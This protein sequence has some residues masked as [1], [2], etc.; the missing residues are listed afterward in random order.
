MPG[1]PN[2]QILRE[3]ADEAAVNER[4]WE[5][6]ETRWRRTSGWDVPTGELGLLAS[7]NDGSH[8]VR[9]KLRT[10][11]VELPADLVERAKN[12]VYSREVLLDIAYWIRTA[13]GERT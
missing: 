7:V 6:F 1:H 8:E 2:A 5:A 12:P 3:I 13:Q 9:R 11:T 10:V 4:Y